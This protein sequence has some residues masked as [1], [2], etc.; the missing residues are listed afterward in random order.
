MIKR[1]FECEVLTPLFLGGADARGAPELRVPSIRGA[2]RYWYRALLGGSVL[3]DNQEP[4]QIL[5]TLENELFGSTDQGGALSTRQRQSSVLPVHAY[6]KDHAIRTPQGGY[7]PSGKDYLLWSMSSSGRPNTPRFQPARQYIQP[8][9]KF[10]IILSAMLDESVVSKG[11]AAFWLLTNLGA[12]GARANRGAGS[13]QALNAD[14]P[15]SFKKCASISTLQ[16]HLKNGIEDCMKLVTDGIWKNISV[17]AQPEYDILHPQAC[18]IWIVADEHGGWSTYLDALNGLG[19]RFRDYRTHINPLGKS[20]HDA[21]LRWFDH[22]GRGPGLKRPVFGLPIPFR[23]SDGGPSDVIIHEKSDR[24]GSP[25]HMRITRLS[26]GKYVGVLTL[27]K[28]RFLPPN[29]ELQLQERK[30]TAPIP[31]NYAVIHDFVQT[32]PVKEQVTP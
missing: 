3:L 18:E 6:E 22:G 10:E 15:I 9:A 28:S 8:G 19:S 32:F 26:D 21:V 1:T 20:D 24:R 17:G 25:L 31:A 13:L 23:Y 2:M 7:L 4:L 14:S 12:V 16:T 11:D 29:T 27:F 5:H 30:W